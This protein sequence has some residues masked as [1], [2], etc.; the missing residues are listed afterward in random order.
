M[1]GLEAVM[2]TLD[3]VPDPIKELYS[4]RNGQFELT[5]IA[6]VKTT[7]DVDRLSVALQKERDAHKDTKTKFSVWGDLEYEDVQKQLDRIP[8]LEAAAQG[9][10]DEDKMNELVEGKMKTRL[11]PIERENNT[12]KAA[13]AERD[14]VI[15]QF[16]AKE[17]QRKIQDTVRPVLAEAKVLESA[18]ED[19]LML[20][21]RLF[22]VREDDGAVVMRDQVGYTPGITVKDWLAEIQSKRPHWWAPSQ[23][24]GSGAGSNLGINSGK[25]PW[26]KDT[27]NLTEQGQVVKEHGL[28]KAQN[29]AKQ[30]GSNV[31][32]VHPPT[33]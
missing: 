23:G 12:L 26:A 24:G 10:I 14:E 2:K 29:L 13:V 9:A 1:S 27:W 19:A 7:A 30:A 31:G 18:Q 21:E 15:G 32:A 33:K 6:G 20:A 5:G 11:A 17:T 3:D 22:E 8:E 25:N 28:D 4:E 16:K